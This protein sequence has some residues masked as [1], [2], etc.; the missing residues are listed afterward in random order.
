MSDFKANMHQIVRQL[1]LCPRPHW[2][3]TVLPRLPCW[4]LGDLLLRERWG[5][6]GRKGEG[7]EGR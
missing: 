7:K 1:G 4:I 3:L 6:E 2:E 5:G